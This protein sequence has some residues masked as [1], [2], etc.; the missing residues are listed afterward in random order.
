M[1][2]GHRYL[3]SMSGESARSQ[4]GQARLATWIG[5]SAGALSAVLGVI[6]EPT[7]HLEILGFLALAILPWAAVIGRPSWPY[8]RY[9]LAGVLSAVFIALAAY[10]R[11]GQEN[12]GPK[13]NSQPLSVAASHLKFLPPA[14]PI[15]HCV[16]FNGT[17]A[18][19]AGD[20]LVLFDRPSDRLGNYT[21]TPAFSYDGPVDASGGGWVA[22]D[23]EIGSGD[24]SDNGAHIAIVAV[25]MPQGAAHF[26]NDLTSKSDS[27][28]VPASV[29]NLGIQADKIVTTRNSQN[30][31]CG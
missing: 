6:A 30:A 28:Q 12:P 10:A 3:R 25:L 9:V 18:I 5:V 17:G 24:S 20:D 29:L 23:Q 7:G 26:L 4:D 31:H 27:G 19:P 1:S 16:T 11:L 14:E 13:D 22:P 8:H 15:P 2:W 21:D